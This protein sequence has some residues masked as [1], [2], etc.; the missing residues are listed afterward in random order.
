[1]AGGWGSTW[2]P[3]STGILALTRWMSFLSLPEGAIAAVGA[4]PLFLAVPLAARLPT[5]YPYRETL[6]GD[7][8]DLSILQEF[9]LTAREK[10]VALL[11]LEGLRNETIRNRL[12]ISAN[13]LKTHL[14][15]LYAKTGTA[16]R[17][18]LLLLVMR[19]TG[20][21][22]AATGDNWRSGPT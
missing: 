3:F 12:Y 4:V 14:K 10:E 11:V 6:L 15:H 2:P 19:R 7:L 16:N 21:A 20:G 9:G 5:P 18:E 1:M 22:E 13:T 8:P 17:K